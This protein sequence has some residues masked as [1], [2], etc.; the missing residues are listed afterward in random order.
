M[1]LLLLLCCRMRDD[2]P[3]AKREGENCE[4]SGDSAAMS[5]IRRATCCLTVR[6]VYS[7]WTRRRRRRGFTSLQLCVIDHKSPIVFEKKK[8][9]CS[10]FSRLLALLLLTKWS[11]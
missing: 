7:K 8:K 1:M 10:V 2:T 3:I 11:A 6:Q 9:T 5:T 4:S